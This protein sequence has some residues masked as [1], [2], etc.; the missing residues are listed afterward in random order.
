M[1]PANTR[2]EQGSGGVPVV[3]VI[4]PARNEEQCLARCLESLVAQQGASFEILVVDDGSTD[5]TRAIADS[6]PQVQVIDAGPL[7]AGWTGKNHVVWQGAQ[8]ARG[9]QH[10][11][12]RE[13]G[14]VR[15]FL[16]RIKD[17]R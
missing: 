8:R 11:S 4:V 7:P 1:M 2:A 13:R 9:N 10:D 3:S 5:R 6:F 12:W 14:K 17:E 15:D 16:P